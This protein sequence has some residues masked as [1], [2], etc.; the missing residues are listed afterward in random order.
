MEKC[1]QINIPFFDFVSFFSLFSFCSMRKMVQSGIVDK[2]KKK[3][4]PKGDCHSTNTATELAFQSTSGIF[5]VYSGFILIS[6]IC[7]IAELLIYRRR[8]EKNKVDT[9]EETLDANSTVMVDLK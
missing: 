2:Y 4:W 3:W 6:V 8:N 7:C 1:V 9:S 5:I